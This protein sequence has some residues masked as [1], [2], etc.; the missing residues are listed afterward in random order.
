MARKVLE[1]CSN[2]YS[3]RPT[4]TMI[5]ECIGQEL[6]SF[7]APRISNAYRPLQDLESKQF[8]S[9]FLTHDD[10]F[11]RYHRYPSSLTF[12]L[13]YGKRMPRG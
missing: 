5:R 3:S 12:A 1:K 9:E 8:V 2:I 7:L 6:G 13:A 10:F 11:K 4:F